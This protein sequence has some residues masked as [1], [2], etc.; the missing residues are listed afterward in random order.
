M[1]WV[2]C[3]PG[4]GLVARDKIPGVLAQCQGGGLAGVSGSEGAVPWL[5]SD[6][7]VPQCRS[8]LYSGSLLV[9]QAMGCLRPGLPVARLQDYMVLPASYRPG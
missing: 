5:P 6:A 8:H 7:D 2:G 9:L 1:G 4:S 3:R